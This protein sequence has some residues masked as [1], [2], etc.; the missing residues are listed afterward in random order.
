MIGI[1]FILLV[2]YQLKHFIADY[3]LQGTYMLG[4]FKPGWDFLGPLTAHCGVHAAMTFVISCVCFFVAYGFN[5]YSLL[6]VGV[7]SLIL[8]ATDFAI[9]FAMDR[10]KAGPK[11]L[12][13]YKAL[14]GAEFMN[15]VQKLKF[16]QSGVEQ[17]TKMLAK[18][19]ATEADKDFWE[20]NRN[21]HQQDV[22]TVLTAFK[23]NV[24]FWWALGLD[25]M[26]HHLTHYGIVYI[27]VTNMNLGQ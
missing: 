10:I 23:N 13:R 11:Y 18:E 26:V 8:A 9:H 20:N 3:P 17:A 6:P 7:M 12:G 22:D 19:G 27:I 15:Y 1:V 21:F 25:Q 4:K 24:Y 5:F 2:V 14:S 16:A